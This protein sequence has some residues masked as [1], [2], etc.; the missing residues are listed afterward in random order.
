MLQRFLHRLGAD[1]AILVSLVLGYACLWLPVTWA[2]Y[3]VVHKSQLTAAN[4]PGASQH[5]GFFNMLGQS[6]EQAYLGCQWG[7][8]Y[9]PDDGLRS[10]FQA[11]RTAS[12]MLLFLVVAPWLDYAFQRRVPLWLFFIVTLVLMLGPALQI[13]LPPAGPTCNPETFFSIYFRGLSFSPMWPVLMLWLISCALGFWAAGQAA[14][15]RI[16]AAATGAG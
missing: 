16:A 9:W 6:A 5:T 14:M 11:W 10:L 13:V 8:F 3:E 4:L 15:P 2:R 12:F 1:R 7:G